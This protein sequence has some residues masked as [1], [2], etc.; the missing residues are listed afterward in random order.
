MRPS[1]L[2]KNPYE[3]GSHRSSNKQATI[4][5]RY[6][7]YAVRSSQFPALTFH[8][9]S[10]ARSRWAYSTSVHRLEVYIEYYVP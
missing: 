8:I 6:T 2:Y 3:S 10:W 5:G 4:S 1:Y 9:V 7:Q